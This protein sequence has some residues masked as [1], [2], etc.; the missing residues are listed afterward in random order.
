MGDRE[1][2]IGNG[3]QAID[4]KGRVGLPADLRVQMEA[5]SGSRSL[6]VDL[7][8]DEDCLVAFDRGFVK[9][10]REQIDRDEAYDRGNGQA[11][12]RAL[13]RRAPFASAEPLPFDASGRFIL[14][15][16]F[17]DAVALT[18][19]AFIVGALD[20]VEI[21]NPVAMLDNPRAASKAKRAAEWHLKQRGRA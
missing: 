2:F 3:L 9:M 13:A 1:E 18:D 11:F 16:Y 6:F 15:P 12:D 21:W 20:F 8:E 4:A 14:P 10:R 7:H 5:N 17:R 19:F